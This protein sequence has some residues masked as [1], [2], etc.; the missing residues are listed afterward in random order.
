MAVGESDMMANAFKKQDEENEGLSMKELF[1]KKRIEAEKKLEEA[2]VTGPS[3]KDV[4]DRKARLLAQRDLLRKQKEAKRQEEL[5][6]FKA[7]TETKEDLF[8]EL[9]KMDDNLGAKKQDDAEAQRRLEQ[10]RKLR[11]DIALENKEE[12]ENKY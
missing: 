10:Y 11:K 7:K 3:K 5:K 4:D 9:K 1:E 12:N 2:K 8:S 6:E